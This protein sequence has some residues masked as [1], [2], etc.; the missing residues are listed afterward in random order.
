MVEPSDSRFD[1][2]PLAAKRRIDA[3]CVRFEAAWRTSRPALE[4][5]VRGVPDNERAVLLTELLYIDIEC[6]RRCGEK[7]GAAD[8]LARF[9]DRR[10]V[11]LEVL[12][13]ASAPSTQLNPALDRTELFPIQEAVRRP[14]QAPGYEVL[15]E[16]GRGGMGIVYRARHLAL[17]R[18]VA[19]QVHPFRRPSLA[20]AAGTLSPRGRGGGPAAPPQ[21]RANLRHWRGGGAIVPGPGVRRRRQPARPS[22]GRAAGGAGGRA[23]AGTAGPAPCST[24]TVR[25]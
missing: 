19:L 17:N 8:Y 12:P 2:L 11:I 4:A 13:L 21:H 25:G 23:A 18:M 20:A 14:F 16:L 6:R 1:S 22:G 10:A 15:D 5:F 9:P 3:V 7:P 24:P